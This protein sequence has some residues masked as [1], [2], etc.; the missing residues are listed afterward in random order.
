MA[1]AHIQIEVG[2][3]KFTAEGSPE[4]VDKKYEEF[5]RHMT[6]L[7]RLLP[8]TSQEEPEDRKLV[9]DQSS[10]PLAIYLKQKNVGANQNNRFL[11]AA[12]WLKSK[13]QNTIKTTEVV[14]AL[15][16]AQQQRLGNPS[17]ILNQNVKKGF[18]VR[19]GDGFYVTPEG[20]ASLR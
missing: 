10:V 17:D 1:E 8:A 3:V 5:L 13:G 14:K 18:C 20:E 16:E 4:W 19:S 11:A 9:G 15:A 12:V 2:K 7:Q 6:E